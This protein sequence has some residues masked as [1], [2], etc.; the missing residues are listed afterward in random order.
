MMEFVKSWITNITVVIIFTMLLDIIIPNNDMKRFLKVIMG[1]LII[2]VIIKPF[3]M[4]RDFGY[5]FQNTMAAT[6]AYIESSEEKNSRSIEVFQNTTALNI[7]KQRLSEKVTEIIQA[8]KE[9]ENRNVHVNVD[10]ENDINKEEFGSIKSIDVI[11]EKGNE[12]AVQ[13]S[14]IEPVNINAETVINKKKGEYNWN[15]SSISQDLSADINDALGLKGTEI[16]V[17]IQE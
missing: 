12:S 17:Q 7:Y 13:A 3:L 14:V 6:T 10:I 8:R 5:Q 1:L 4:A 2:L 9:L 16:S 15:N 11:V